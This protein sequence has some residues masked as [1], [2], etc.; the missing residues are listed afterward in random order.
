M[1]HLL[2]LYNIYLFTLEYAAVMACRV[3]PSCCFGIIKRVVNLVMGVTN[4]ISRQLVV[5]CM[6]YLEIHVTYEFQLLGQG[7]MNNFIIV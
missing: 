5:L 3:S 2:L 4:C 6:L 7:S 1:Y